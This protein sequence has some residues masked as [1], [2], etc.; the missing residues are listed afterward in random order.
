M[1]EIIE[2]PL[3]PYADT[4]SVKENI[5]DVAEYFLHKKAMTHRRLQTFCFLAQVCNI[6]AYGTELFI[7]PFEAWTNGPTSIKIHDAYSE[8]KQIPIITIRNYYIK[9]EK[10]EAILSRTWD[11][12]AKYKTETL[13]GTI[14]ELQGWKLLTCHVNPVTIPD[15][16]I[17]EFIR[18]YIK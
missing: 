5:I 3:P 4:T 8:W 16:L 7:E 17:N 11:C 13:I 9:T 18:R 2:M 15:G 1:G 10:H 12:F 14:Q 6:A